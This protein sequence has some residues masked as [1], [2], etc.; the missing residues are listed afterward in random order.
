MFINGLKTVSIASVIL[1]NTVIG[2]VA[3]TSVAAALPA[4]LSTE[5]T[6][7]NNILASGLFMTVEQDHP[8]EGMARI[9]NENGKRYLEFDGAF[10][11]AKGP[12][13][14][15]ILHRNSSIPVNL[16]EGEYITLA[17]LQS[18]DGSQ[19]YLLP[20]DLDLSQYKSVG[21][22]CREFNVTFGYASL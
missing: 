14:N 22:W 5:I 1:L 11:T 7:Q 2:E 10:T 3:F 21:I 17:S 13:V 12:D 20:N 8:T 9:V 19:R 18:F 6:A 4:S 15:V 16:K